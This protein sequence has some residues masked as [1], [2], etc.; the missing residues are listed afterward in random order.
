MK[1]Q[2]Q[3]DIREVR[4]SRIQNVLNGEIKLVGFYPKM[5]VTKQNIDPNEKFIEEDFQL[6]S[7]NQFIQ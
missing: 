2:I 4:N 6:K 7:W 1:N 5:E 3:R